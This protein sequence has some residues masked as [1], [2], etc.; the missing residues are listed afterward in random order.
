LD[1]T[2]H[3]ARTLFRD[4]P[5]LQALPQFFFQPERPTEYR[6]RRE[7]KLEYVS[8][9]EAVVHALSLLEPGRSFQSL[10]DPFRR[11]ID[12]HIE[13]TTRA[14]RR[15]R[16]SR[17][18]PTAARCLPHALVE[19]FERAVLVYGESMTLQPG[20]RGA[21]AKRLVYWTAKRLQD[22]QLFSSVVRPAEPFSQERWRHLGLGPAQAAESVTLDELR[23]RWRAFSRPDDVPI[24][25][26]SSTLDCMDVLGGA[27]GG[28]T[29][30]AAYRSAPQ[31]RAPSG[32]LE[33]VVNVE[34]L[35]VRRVAVPGRAGARLAAAEAVARHLHR[36]A[37]GG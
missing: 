36:M 19:N 1:G 22:E 27:R 14:G 21:A 31:A 6:V 5:P 37:T 17:Q 4:S 30:K 7:P 8:T 18:R 2:W 9:V 29:L 25:W 10:L 35:P 12:L 13:A 20:K 28:V 34:G 32:S 3:Q 15:P 24:A 16:H 23:R 33:H 11:M 26:N